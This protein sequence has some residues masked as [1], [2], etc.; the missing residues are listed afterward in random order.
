[1]P[2]DSRQ[3]RHMAAKGLQCC[4]VLFPLCAEKGG[5]LWVLR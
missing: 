1:M 3:H 4:A 5:K 2:W